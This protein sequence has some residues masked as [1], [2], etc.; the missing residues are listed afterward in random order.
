MKR[1][2]KR[3][4][5]S[6]VL[7]EI[8]RLAVEKRVAF[9]HKVAQEIEALGLGLDFDDVCDVIKSLAE[10]DFHKR[11]TS[12]ITR[13][14]LYVFKPIV[15]GTVIYVKLILREDCIVISFHEDEDEI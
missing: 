6:G 3:K 15:C 1:A 5:L 8:H 2:E 12:V 9:T 10:D 7:R 4:W 13:E 14:W 11:V